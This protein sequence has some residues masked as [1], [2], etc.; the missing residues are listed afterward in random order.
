MTNDISMKT[1]TR[2]ALSLVLLFLFSCNDEDQTFNPRL[3][4]VQ[5]SADFINV[6]SNLY[7][8]ASKSN[9]DIIDHVKLENDKTFELNTDVYLDQTF[10][11]SLVEKYEYSSGQ[12]TELSGNSFHDIQRGTT[13]FLK[14]SISENGNVG[15]FNFT[16]Q[17]IETANAISY[18][19]SSN[20]DVVSH[21]SITN[22]D[23]NHTIYSK[24]PT[25]LFIT[26]YNA[27]EE[28][29]SYLFPL[30]Q[31]TVM[32]QY[33]ID[34]RGDYTTFET[35]EVNFSDYV[36]AGVKVYGRT[37]PDSFIEEYE[38]SNSAVYYGNTLKV[39]YPGD[40]FAAYASRSW[41]NENGIF[42]E[43]FNKE[44]R[45][46]FD[47]LN[48]QIELANTPQQFTY[49][50]TGDG[51]ILRFDFNMNG[52]EFET[53]DWNSFANAGINKQLTIPK[54]PIEIISDLS[55]F[56]YDSWSTESLVELMEVEGIY[57]IDEYLVSEA[58]GAWLGSKNTKYAYGYFGSG[59]AFQLR[60]NLFN[61]DILAS[62]KSFNCNNWFKSDFI[63]D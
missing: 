36:F 5:V 49:S 3:I 30:A 56:N 53:Y 54:L 7:L 9:G 52:N 4:T 33:A 37:S 20:G 14:R 41:I 29:V 45:N 8:L 57:S 21:N 32:N 51:L 17:N 42:F 26:K 59:N 1:M 62:T 2:L 48:A 18:S 38:V 60:F 19:I 22:E 31:H 34:I 63:Y 35:E 23:F 50:V 28:P 13:L 11:L 15:F 24:N 46:D 47:F 40:I 25:R 43:N 39:Y 6:N 27:Q 55:L 16:L 10:T 58:K 44:K 61:E 12:K